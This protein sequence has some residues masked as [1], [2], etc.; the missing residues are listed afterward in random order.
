MMRLPSEVRA[1]LDGL[2]AALEDSL[3]SLTDRIDW[4][5][6]ADAHRD[7]IATLSRI[8]DA[9]T[10]DEK[11]IDSLESIVVDMKATREKWS[12]E[13]PLVKLHDRGIQHF[14]EA[15]DKLRSRIP[16]RMPLPSIN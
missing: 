5:P 12:E 10:I 8:V 15:S 4:K 3:I 9:E 14:T 11:A 2:R 16:L 1:S 13:P 7:W 6:I